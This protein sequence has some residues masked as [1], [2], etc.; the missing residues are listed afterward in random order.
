MGA[1]WRRAAGPALLRGVRRAAPRAPRLAGGRLPRCH[2]QVRVSTTLHDVSWR[3]SAVLGERD[4][5]EQVIELKQQ[6]GKDIIVIGSPT[7]VRWL[8]RNDL[9]DELNLTVLPIIVGSGVRLFEDMDMPGGH[10]GMELGRAKT[11]T[12]GALELTYTP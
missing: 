1:G 8:L 9:L 7:L 11:L 2:P 3:E 10:L 6:P 4:L 12:S 5:R